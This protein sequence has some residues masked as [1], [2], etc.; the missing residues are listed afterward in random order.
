MIPE[1]STSVKHND[2]ALGL[3]YH[4]FGEEYSGFYL[5][6]VTMKRTNS[7]TSDLESRYFEWPAQDGDAQEYVLQRSAA[8]L[9]VYFCAHLL[10]E[11]KRL[12]RYAAPITALYV[13][14]DGAVELSDLPATAVVES[15]P[16]RHHYYYRL[17]E[18]TS[19]REAQ[20]RNSR[21][22]KAMGADPSGADLTQLLRVP[23]TYNH[24]REGA[25]S[26]VRLLNLSDT[27]YAASELDQALP[28]GE[29][30]IDSPSDQSISWDALDEIGWELEWDYE[31]SDN[32]PLPLSGD[33]L[34]KWRGEMPF[35]R[36]DGIQ[37][38]RS[39]TLMSIGRVIWNAVLMKYAGDVETA[40]TVTCG[41]LY[42]RDVR[43]DYNKYSD[44]A[45]ALDLY[46]KYCVKKYE[47][48][49]A[50]LILK[51][52]TDTPESEIEPFPLDALPAPIREYAVEA[53]D[54]RT[55]PID[56][57]VAAL[58]IQATAIM[59][60]AWRLY[61]SGEFSVQASFYICIVGE[62]GTMKT[63]ALESGLSVLYAM[64]QEL[65]EA[66]DAELKEYYR[67]LATWKEDGKKA[68]G[69]TKRGPMPEEPPR[70]TLLT[71]DATTEGLVDLMVHSNGILLEQDELIGLIQ[72]FDQ[73][74]G[75][76][77]ADRQ[78]YLQF[79]NG[80]RYESTRKTAKSNSVNRTHLS[81]I[82]GIQPDLLPSLARSQS[83]Q[84]SDGFFERFLGVW[85]AR[86]KREIR[87]GAIDPVV[88][89]L[90]ERI[91]RKLARWTQ[92][93]SAER[94]RKITLSD[95]AFTLYH[96]WD[97]HN[98][99]LIWDENLKVYRG[100]YDKMSGHCARLAL[101]LHAMESV[102]ES[103]QPSGR[104]RES[105]MG[106]PDSGTVTAETMQKAI[107]LIEYF[108]S[109]GE[110]VIDCMSRSNSSGANAAERVK[111]Y[112]GKQAGR[113]VQRQ[114]L[115]GKLRIRSE[116]LTLT[117]DA[118]VADGSIQTEQ[119]ITLGRPAHLYWMP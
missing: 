43:L 100:S 84:G 60:K 3:W 80:K 90:N 23:G 63:P 1:K 94:P 87:R 28:A 85:P 21:L 68:E 82:G 65:K 45:N 49:K 15:S 31:D 112:L 104:F 50:P 44:R 79:D 96:D 41:A 36:E 70:R 58:I 91:Y 17:D 106:T 72:S 18:P 16:G 27:H 97:E 116:A 14:G 8:G 66:Q 42:N 29:R 47:Q 74:R 22:A 26:P 20:D 35:I 55:C 64:H 76:K 30:R 7:K 53:A 69:K 46:Y 39:S 11:R 12:A 67:A 101:V 6:I 40:I 54:L 5:C 62:T 93:F 73:Y 9:E 2:D 103:V 110:R 57:V 95:E 102:T 78:A 109:H 32:P 105:F 38:D 75:G 71:H 107:T 56:Y 52:K 89:D 118:L 88:K 114:E 25:V 115:T 99:D 61:I 59:G 108:R 83:G 113:K 98:T 24:K 51:A 117:L 10:T 13:D 48:D 81:I 77:G 86:M 4:L 33:D 37:V 92:G 111:E 119:E 34:A 19:P